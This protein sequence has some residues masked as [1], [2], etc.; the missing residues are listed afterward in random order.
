MKQNTQR[1]FGKSKRYKFLILSFA[2]SWQKYL[3]ESFFYRLFRIEFW[4][5][6]EWKT[7]LKE[8]KDIQKEMNRI[9]TASRKVDSKKSSRSWRKNLSQR[10]NKQST[11]LTLLWFSCDDVIR[12]QLL[13]QYTVKSL[14]LP[15]GTNFFLY[16]WGPILL[17][18]IWSFIWVL[19]KSGYYSRA[20]TNGDFTYIS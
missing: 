10:R 9:S 15:A 6:E 1:D 3:F 16:F 19:F 2:F 17:S 7:F 5:G 13:I 12:V 4:W 14:I 18:K 8:M 20:G 11:F